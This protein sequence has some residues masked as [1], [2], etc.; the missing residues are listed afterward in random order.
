[1]KTKRKHKFSWYLR[2]LLSLT[3]ILLSIGFFILSLPIWKLSKVQFRGSG[4]ISK[5]KIIRV[6]DIP[7]NENILL[8][9]SKSIEKRLESI[10]QIRS[11]KIRK[12][13]PNTLVVKL[14]ERTPF[15]LVSV[16]SKTVL[17]DSEGYIIATPGKASYYKTPDISRFPIISGVNFRDRT[18]VSKSLK[19]LSRYIS[20]ESLQ[21]KIGNL[22]NIVIYVED[23]LR[24]E[25]GDAKNI[26]KKVEAF[27]AVL[28]EIEGKWEEVE[29]INVK[30]P[31]FPVVK[32]KS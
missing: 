30:I 7:L 11:V 27:G 26:E 31:A 2:W 21:I 1:M 14:E 16:G 25:L 17:I 23:V 6:A 20:P 28:K 4:L 18:F 24:L 13:L 8:V 5:A 9:D 32:Y 3:V 29:Y 12:K 10:I 22:D 19:L 15:A